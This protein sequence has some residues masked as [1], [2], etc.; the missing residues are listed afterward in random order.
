MSKPPALR[1]SWDDYFLMLAK[2]AA[3]RSTCLSRPTGAVIVLDRR[4]LA[5]GYNGSMP[6]SPH[7]SDEGECYRRK[8]RGYDEDNKYDICRAIHAEA[9]A[10]A[11]AA[12]Q[13]ISVEGATLYTTLSPCFSCTKLLASARILRLVFEHEYESPDPQRD[14]IWREAIREAGIQCEQRTLPPEVIELAVRYL[15]EVTSRR[16]LPKLGQP[17][18]YF[19]RLGALKADE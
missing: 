3:T 2:L 8:L 7:C 10:L 13:G 19:D 4:V 5:T 6:G 17:P 11:Q 14:R 9:N 18:L 16:R 1:P 12:R 15:S